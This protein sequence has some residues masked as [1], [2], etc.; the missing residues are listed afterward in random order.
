MGK[1]WERCVKKV[2]KAQEKRYGKQKYNPY[3]VCTK[4]VGR[5]NAKGKSNPFSKVLKG[6]ET[7]LKDPLKVIRDNK[8][9][10]RLNAC[11]KK[12]R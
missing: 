1:K 10:L 5:M 2:T 6:G 9:Y 7:A 4:S 8:K 12:K 11:K 3:A